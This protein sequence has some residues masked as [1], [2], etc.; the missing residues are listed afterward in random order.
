MGEEGVE[1]RIGKRTH[2]GGKE[3]MWD[4]ERR[5][6]DIKRK[7]LPQNT[8]MKPNIVYANFKGFC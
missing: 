8:V 4:G 5:E 7:F 6:E 1:D 3:V 2:E